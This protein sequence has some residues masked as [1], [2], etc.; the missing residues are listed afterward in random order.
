MSTGYFIVKINHWC[1]ALCFAFNLII[2]C[3][4]FDFLVESFVLSSKQCLVL[5]DDLREILPAVE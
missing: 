5:V 3:V 1:R 4:F 2:L